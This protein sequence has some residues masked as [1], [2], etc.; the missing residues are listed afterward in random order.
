MDDF[1]LQVGS[2]HK[3]TFEILEISLSFALKSQQ[4]Q[5]QKKKLMKSF[6]LHSLGQTFK[7]MIFLNELK[8]LDF[9]EFLFT[10]QENIMFWK[11]GLTL[12]SQKKK[13]YLSDR[14]L[15]RF[16]LET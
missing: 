12:L 10:Y 16:L 3:L 2:K 9:L 6:C 5:S 8:Y 14:G 1:Y 11:L 13:E 7:M 15:M 4:K